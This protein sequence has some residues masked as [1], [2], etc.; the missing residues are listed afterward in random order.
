M[1]YLFSDQNGNYDATK[2]MFVLMCIT[3][4]FKVLFSGTTIMG[5]AFESVDYSGLAMIVGA[6]AAAHFG[7]SHTKAKG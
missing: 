4:I 7:R 3:A 1:K 5:Y 6:F 2:T